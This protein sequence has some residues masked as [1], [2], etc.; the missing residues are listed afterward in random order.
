M[1]KGREIRIKIL[2][3][4]NC[5]KNEL[6]IKNANIKNTKLVGRVR[7]TIKTLTL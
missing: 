5:I 2:H 7:I 1:F 6:E 3:E 4:E